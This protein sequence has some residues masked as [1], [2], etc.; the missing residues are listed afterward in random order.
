M[1]YRL[2]TPEY[3]MLWDLRSANA[4][5]CYNTMA[6]ALAIVRR[7]LDIEGPELAILETID[8][9]RLR[10]D[11]LTIEYPITGEGPATVEKLGNIRKLFERTKLYREVTII[12][13]SDVVFERI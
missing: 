9:D 2:R 3:W 6:D 7:A 10:I 5:G 4:I 11:V 13:G 12:R 8:F 1:T